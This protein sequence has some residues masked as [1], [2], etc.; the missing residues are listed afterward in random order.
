MHCDGLS[1][2]ELEGLKNSIQEEQ[3]ANRSLGGLFLIV[4]AL[5]FA[6]LVIIF[7]SKN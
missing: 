1:N 2:G 6:A 3:Q 4:S 7:F 5:I